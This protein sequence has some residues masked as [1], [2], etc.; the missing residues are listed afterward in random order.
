VESV[1]AVSDLIAPLSGRV[2]EVN[3]KVVDAPETVNEDPYGDGWLIRIELT[4]F[5]EVDELLDAE[6][7]RKLIAEQ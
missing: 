6:A 3:Q 7:Y 5:A 2:V 1:K 4:D